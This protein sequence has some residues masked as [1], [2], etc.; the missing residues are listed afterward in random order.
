MLHREIIRKQ[1][2]GL[3]CRH[4]HMIGSQISTLPYELNQI[5]TSTIDKPRFMLR[6]KSPDHKIYHVKF[7]I[8]TTQNYPSWLPARHQPQSLTVEKQLQKAIIQLNIN[9]ITIKNHIN[10]PPSSPTLTSPFLHGLEPANLRRQKSCSFP[11][12]WRSG[13]RRRIS[14]PS[15]IFSDE[16]PYGELDS[17]SYAPSNRSVCGGRLRWREIWR[18]ITRGKKRISD[19]SASLAANVPYDPYTYAQNFDEGSA[20]VEPENLSRSF[21][22]RFAAPSGGL[23]RFG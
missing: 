19:S 23:R 1:C 2:S 7:P 18:R 12:A 13:S 22:A 11:S 20:W 15:G 17:L 5:V 6:P 10:T 14:R 21:S 16:N 3:P 9:K 4:G 8:F